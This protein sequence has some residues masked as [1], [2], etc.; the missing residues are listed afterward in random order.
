MSAA[1]NWTTPIPLLVNKFVTTSGV[2]GFHLIREKVFYCNNKVSRV[3]F[4]S[5]Y[6]ECLIREL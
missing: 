1:E 5:V 2:K 4:L 3:E 6:H